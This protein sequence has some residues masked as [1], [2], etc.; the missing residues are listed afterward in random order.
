MLQTVEQKRK[1]GIIQDVTKVEH[2][3]CKEETV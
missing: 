1:S 2:R 3:R